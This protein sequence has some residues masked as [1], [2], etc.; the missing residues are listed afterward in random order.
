MKKWLLSLTTVALA[1]IVLAGCS[2]NKDTT[3][4]SETYN[5][6]MTRGKNAASDSDYNAAKAYFLSALN[7]KTNDSKGLAYQKQADAL[8]KA[9]KAMDDFDFT[10][11][12]SALR[13]VTKVANGYTG[14]NKEANSLLK[15]VNTI[16]KHRSALRSLLSQAKDQLDAKQN[17]TAVSTIKQLLDK[18]YIQDDYYTDIYEDAVELLVTASETTTDNNGSDVVSKDSDTDAKD[19]KTS[20]SDSSDTNGAHGDYVE[21]DDKVSNDDIADARA[22]LKKAGTNADAWSDTDIQTAIQNAAKDGRKAN[23][24]TADD[25]R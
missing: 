2:T 15:K 21:R 14:M 19:S 10:E 6:A 3:D 13:S 17:Q 12:Q 4:N 23:Q 16:K 8:L 9:Q 22:A 25:I 18:K 11:A 20:S 7:V 1:T 5:T 24:I